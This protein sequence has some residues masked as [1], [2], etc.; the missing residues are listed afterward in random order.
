MSK[1][2]ILVDLSGFLCTVLSSHASASVASKRRFVH[3][4]STRTNS[5]PT[6]TAPFQQRLKSIALLLQA[7]TLQLPGIAAG[8]LDVKRSR[9]AGSFEKPTGPLCWVYLW[10]LQHLVSELLVPLLRRRYVLCGQRKS[11]V[12]VVLNGQ[13]L[14]KTFA[15]GGRMMERRCV[16][17]RE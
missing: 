14:R 7:Q 1:Q 4:T 16:G 9:A 15:T 8:T 11:E 12:L 2:T 17:H 10:S 5:F 13:R 3:L 6:Q